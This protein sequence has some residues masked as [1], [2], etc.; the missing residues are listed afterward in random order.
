MYPPL[1]LVAS[2]APAFFSSYCPTSVSFYDVRKE[3]QKQGKHL[4]LGDGCALASA[5]AR[6]AIA[7]GRNFVARAI[8]SIARD[9]EGE[10]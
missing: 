5:S 1:I 3:A 7:F 2:S 6:I 8:S 9:S 4:I 10:R